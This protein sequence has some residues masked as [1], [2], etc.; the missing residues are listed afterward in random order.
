MGKYGRDAELEHL[1]KLKGSGYD[2]SCSQ[3]GY[4]YKEEPK[5]CEQCGGVI[6]SRTSEL[7]KKLELGI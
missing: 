3:C 6:F 5:K 2:S 4:M 1:D 7:I